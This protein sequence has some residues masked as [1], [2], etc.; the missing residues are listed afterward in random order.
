VDRGRVGE[1][2]GRPGVE[3]AEL[4]RSGSVSPVEV[5]RA[6]LEQVE[7]LDDHLGAFVRVRRE[8][9]TE[10][11]E[12][13][14]TRPDLSALPLAGVPVAVKDNVPVAG[15]PM[16]WGS[17]ATPEAPQREDHEVVRRLR[18][19]GAVVVGITRMPELGAWATT[20]GPSG[21]ARNPW[22]PER[23]P[24]GSSGGSAVAVAAGMVP[25]AHGN[26]GLGSIRIPAAACGLV[27][28]KP[29]PGVVPAAIGATSWRGLAENGVLATTV[30]D[31]A[32]ALSVIAGRP[33]LRHASPPHRPLRVAVSARSPLPGVRA[34]R[35]VGAAV[36]ATARLLSGAGH[37]VRR[38]D[39]PYTGALAR[40]GVLWWAAL[41]AEEAEAMVRAGTLDPRRLEPRT[42]RHVAVGRG[43]LRLR[44]AREGDLEAW[45]RRAER[46]MEGFDLLLAPALARPPVRAVEWHR[47]PWVANVAVA[48]R[49]APFAGPWNVARFPAVVVPAGF[50]SSGLPLSVQLVAGPGGERTLLAAA[51][52]LEALR[53][54]PRHAPVSGLR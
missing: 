8:R 32:L 50:H 51:A 40:T 23:T 2:V 18:E 19:A 45:R 10:E 31:A 14:A 24:G 49:Y 17:V 37:R 47:R 43:A 4:V 52:Q 39:P 3:L 36:L 46:F 16:R 54:W 48:A 12:R 15:E 25:V 20:D 35:E 29:G 53:P 1:L 42:R 38:A 41:V 33:D 5:V 26:D 11:A 22:N 21:T 9:A 44:V 6:H 27:G 13:L 34:E 30:A 7:A 28:V